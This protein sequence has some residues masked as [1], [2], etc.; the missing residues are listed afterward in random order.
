LIITLLGLAALVMGY[1]ALSQLG[2]LDILTSETRLQQEV[3]RLGTWGVVLLI[4]AMA[5]AIVMSPIPSGPIA[6]VAGA[7][8]GPIW[9]GIYT[10]IGSVLG[11]AIAFGLARWL[12]YDFVRRRLK[13]QLPE[14]TKKR[15]QNRLTGIVFVTRLVP[16]ISFDAVS[17]V[18]GL[19]PLT[20]PRFFS[21]TLIGVIPISFLL[22]FFGEQL[23]ALDAQWIVI[24]TVL[25]GSVTLLPLLSKR[26]RDKLRQ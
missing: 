5:L 1:L 24:G 26:F 21:A 13:R 17:Y 6:M 20:F 19:T 4:L 10:V 3:E 23:L 12:G 7:V 18:A 9:G 8:F 22:T 15:S 2:Y 11:A 16:F 25:V 14:L